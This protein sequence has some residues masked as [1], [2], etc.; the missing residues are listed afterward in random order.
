MAR[1]DPPAA[2]TGLVE[3]FEAN[4]VAYESGHYNE[5]QV[6]REF[7][8]PLLKALGW[9][10]DNTAGYAEAYKD[11]VHEDAIRVEGSP[12]APDY[13]VR[14][15]GARK[16]FVEAKKPSINLRIDPYPAYQLRRYAWSAKLPLSILT[17]FAE[18]AVYDCRV[19][20]EPTDK[21]SKARILYLTCDEYE[22]RWAE[23]ASVFSRDAVLKGSFDSFAETTKA[24]RGTTEVDAAFLAEIE[25]WRAELARN[26][27]LRNPTLRARELNFAVQTT[28]DRI[29]FL[30]ICEDRGLEPYGELRDAIQ[31]HD[32]YGRLMGLFRQADERYNSGLFH[33]EREKGRGS[34]DDLTPGLLIDDKTLRG[35]VGRLYYPESP[36]EF[37]VI[38]A[39]I[40]GQVYEQFLGR[41]I[42]LSPA[43]RV[44]IDDKPEVK[45]AGG[46]YY[47]PAYVVRFIVERSVGAALAARNPERLIGGRHRESFRALDPACGS[48]SFLIASY[49]YLLDWYLA[50]YSSGEP[51]KWAKGR[52]PRLYRNAHGEWRLTTRERKRI[53]TEHI[54][55]VDI[56]PQAVEVTKL[57]LML[58]VLEGESNELIQQ[59][60][61]LFNERA[62]PDLDNNIKCGNSLI[63]TDF[64]D[65]PQMRLLSE[66]R[67]YGVNVFDWAAEF[68]GIV[69]KDAPGFEV[70]VG[71][72]PWGASFTAEELAYARSHYR[73][74]IARMIDSYIYFLDRSA[75]LAKPGAPIGFIVPSTILNQVDAR[76]IRD[77]LLERGLSCLVS[78]GQGIFGAKVLNTS[79]ILVSETVA[80]TDTFFLDDLRGSP[81]A[82]RSAALSEPQ[83]AE[84]PWS[85]WKAFVAADPHTTFSVSPLAHTALLARLR[86]A[87]RSLAQAVQGTIQR[88][89]SP[90][91]AA[92]HVVDDETVEAEKLESELLRPSVSANQVRRYHR[93]QR[94]Q[95][96][97]YTT[98]TSPLGKC[99]N[100]ERHLRGFKHLN[101]CKEV[102]AGKHPW[103]ALHRPRD[104][105]IF[106]SPKLI[107]LT[108]TKTI[109]I[110]YDEHGSY[111]V[112]DAMYVLTLVEGEDP[113]AFMA[114][115]Q[116]KLMLFLYRVANQGESRVIP[117]IKATKLATLPYPQLTPKDARELAQL[118][119]SLHDLHA[120]AERA[121]SPHERQTQHRHINAVERQID[122]IVYRVCGLTAAEIR[123]VEAAVARRV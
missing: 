60:L 80:D 84:T 95:F 40:L 49:Q 101:T 122:Q 90:D 106:R 33:F 114:V 5:T 11:V 42:S 103:W 28:I 3:R 102:P 22:T 21:P 63:E 94:D 120:D 10:I 64:Y 29:V 118:S 75:Q 93:P 78:L 99:P 61:R 76:P 83:M 14:I 111:T 107:G 54:F 45:K 121:S 20:P 51:E 39:D 17:D 100:I 34:P 56:D 104:P 113:W 2:V 89:V 59:E 16:F 44:K 92:A 26:V 67:R 119:R 68:P 66:E 48:G 30:R 88:G 115:M 24:K 53:V 15:G 1:D 18:L 12:K 52:A 62:L 79:T 47:T 108:T 87:H 110:V 82:E 37:S 69:G 96:I 57:S 36:Y 71:N 32:V 70:I 98:R 25:T 91:V 74:V 86:E 31:G 9:D 109:E 35:I 77:L 4:R 85:A 58:K 41:V 27:A 73:R 13:S 46:V 55:G 8:D 105:A 123:T 117:Q 23:L 72:P 50:L 65:D 116:S 19:K 81:L 97:I 6:R 43:G 7:I 112:T 38:S